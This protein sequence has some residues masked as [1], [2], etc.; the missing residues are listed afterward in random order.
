MGQGIKCME[1]DFKKL[2][3]YFSC[4]EKITELLCLGKKKEARDLAENGS[5]EGMQIK[6]I[7]KDWSGLDSDDFLNFAENIPGLL[8]PVRSPCIPEMKIIKS[9]RPYNGCIF[10]S[11]VDTPFGKSVISLSDIGICGI[12]FPSGEQDPFS[13]IKKRWP[14]SV[15]S[16]DSADIIEIRDLIFSNKVSNTRGLTLHLYGTDFQMSVWESLSKIPLGQRMS[17][18]DIAASVGRPGAS[19]AVGNAV[20][21]NPIGY[22]LPCHRVIPKSG[23]I[24]GF[25]SGPAKKLA[26]LIYENCRRKD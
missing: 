10:Y 7:L 6:A 26:M 8:I 14:Q 4:V 23:K 20:G 2:S 17:Y 1:K 15:R 3:A 19:R 11:D 16:K 25:S 18:S 12:D 13:D 9:N 21:L 22:L 24:G 5:D